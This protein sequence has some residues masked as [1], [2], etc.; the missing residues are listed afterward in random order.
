MIENLKTVI[1]HGRIIDIRMRQCDPGGNLFPVFD[2]DIVFVPQ[3]A[4]GLGYFGQYP[5]V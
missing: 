5:R 2:N 3:I 4:A 1:R